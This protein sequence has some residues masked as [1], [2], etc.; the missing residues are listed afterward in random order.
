MISH[1]EYDGFIR[2]LSQLPKGSSESYK[3]PI[4]RF[5]NPRFSSN[6]LIMSGRGA[7]SHSGRWHP[8]GRFRCLYGTTTPETALQE[9]LSEKRYYA[10]PD[11]TAL[12][13]LL[14]CIEANL[15]HL[16]NLTDGKIRQRMRLSLNNIVNCHWRDENSFDNKESIT[17]AFGR[18]VHEKGFEGLIV[19]SSAHQPQGVNLV[20]F[21]DN[22]LHD[23]SLKLKT[24]L[25]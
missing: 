20:I 22:K 25:D 19:P 21:P 7:L 23:H 3:G 16:L 14:V 18:A 9:A 8:A 5:A 11:D 6:D 10:L 1:S 13:K 24:P 4:Y 15:F 12:P 2:R 17:Q